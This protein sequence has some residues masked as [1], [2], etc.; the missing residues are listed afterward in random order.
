[1]DETDLTGVITPGFL[2]D[3]GFDFDILVYLVAT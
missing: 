3:F 2:L 1:M